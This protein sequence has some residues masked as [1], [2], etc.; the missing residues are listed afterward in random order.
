MRQDNMTM[1]Q[2]TMRLRKEEQAAADRSPAI[3]KEK[4]ARLDAVRGC[5]Y[6]G[7]VG[8]ALGYPVEFDSERAIFSR[9]GSRGITEYETDRRTGKAL[10][11]DDTQ[12]TLFT[13]NGLLVGDTREAMSGDRA[14]P[15]VYVTKAYLDWLMTQESSMRQ[16][17]RHERNTEEGGYSWLLDVPELYSRRAPGNTC[18]SALEQEEAGISYEDYIEAKRNHSK[19]C[20]GIMRVAPI[21]VNYR[22]DMERLDLEGSDICRPRSWSISSTGSYFLR[23]ERNNP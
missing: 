8:D 1:F 5:I 22:T 23:R 21:A 4:E 7:A 16:V 9:Y 3:K 15:R 20:G 2:E 19:G 6:G 13:A 10:I 12:M 17:N 18:L 14:W 11:S